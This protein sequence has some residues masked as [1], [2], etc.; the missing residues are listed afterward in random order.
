VIATPQS[1][2]ANGIISPTRRIWRV[3]LVF[4]DGSERVVCVSP[5]RLDEEE[6]VAR[7]KRHAG[8][9]D[10]SILDRVE[11]SAVHRELQST[12]FGVVQK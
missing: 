9:F 10:S 4:L 8:V 7:A 1:L 3:R 5:G 12:P 6:A 2:A 11:A